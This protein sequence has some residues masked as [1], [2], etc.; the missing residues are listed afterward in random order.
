VRGQLVPYI[1]LREH[2]QAGGERPD[3]EQIVITNV[4]NRRV[5]MVVDTVVGEHQTVIK[6]LGRFYRNVDGISGA[7]IL[8]NG[9]VALILDVPKLVRL[10]E[11]QERQG[12][13]RG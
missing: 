13:H 12:V 7:T 9:T 3:F 5:G 11:R 4:D 6:S 1:L 2:F 8:G 10:V